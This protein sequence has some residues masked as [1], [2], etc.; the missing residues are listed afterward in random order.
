MV[1]VRSCRKLG[2]HGRA[3]GR[4]RFGRLDIVVN[5]AAGNFLVP[6]EDLRPKGF[7][8]VI[9]IDTV[10]TC[11][12][13]GPRGEIPAHAHRRPPR[14]RAVPSALPAGR[15]GVFNICHAAFPELK[16]SGDALIINISATLHYGATWYQVHASA[17]KAAIDRCV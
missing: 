4:D 7:K 14:S 6:A 1:H 11:A 13:A 12:G 2:R 10:G 15:P 3:H 16:K 8:T 9:E 17:A 5:N